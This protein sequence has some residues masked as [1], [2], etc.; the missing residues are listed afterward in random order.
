M[1]CGRLYEAELRRLQ[2]E[3]LL[4]RDGLAAAEDALVCFRHAITLGQEQAALAWQLRAAM[5]Q[6]RLYERLAADQL[7]ELEGARH[8]L[9]AL[10]ARYTEGHHLPDLCEAA[11]FLGV[12]A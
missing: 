9:A 5:S 10:Y 1:R 12:A 7:P 3:L 6:V 2:G 4:E 8:T 11:A